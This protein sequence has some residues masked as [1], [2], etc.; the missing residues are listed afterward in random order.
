[1]IRTDGKYVVNRAASA[2]AN[3]Q[4]MTS[5]WAPMKKS[6][7]GVPGAASR[8]APASR[9]RAAWRRRR[10]TGRTWRPRTRCCTAARRLCGATRYQGGG[11]RDGKKALD[12]DWKTAMKP[13]TRRL[14]D[15]AGPEDAEE[16]RKASVPAKVEHPFLYVKRHFVR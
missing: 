13:G 1:M 11:R 12:V 6:R 16:K 9:R 15:E 5:A 2:V 7:I 8:T 4:P 14:L 10:R 3:A